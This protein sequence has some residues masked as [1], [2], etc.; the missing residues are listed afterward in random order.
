[1]TDKDSNT[2][3]HIAAQNSQNASTS[4]V[5]SVWKF[6]EEECKIDRFALNNKQRTARF[7]LT[8]DAL[9]H[10]NIETN[11]QETKC[12]P[13]SQQAVQKMEASVLT[14]ACGI[15]VSKA[16]KSRAGVSLKH[17]DDGSVL[18]VQSTSRILKSQEPLEAKSKTEAKE[19]I[20]PA[21]YAHAEQ[22]E[23]DYPIATTSKDALKKLV[24]DLISKKLD[25]QS[26]EENLV[27]TE[28]QKQE[29]VSNAPLEETKRGSD[30]KTSDQPKVEKDFQEEEKK[31]EGQ[32]WE[33]EIH[34]NVAA[35]TK[36]KAQPYK[37]RQQVF[38]KLYKLASGDWNEKNHKLLVNEDGIEIYEARLTKAVRIL[39]QIVVRFSISLTDI[40]ADHG[41][42]YS[43]G[44]PIHV[45]SE[46]IVVW[47]IVE[48][49]DKIHHSAQRIK[50]AIQNL[51]WPTADMTPVHKTWHT[52]LK[53]DIRKPKVF[54]NSL[55]LEQQLE[56]EIMDKLSC[57]LTPSSD[58]VREYDVGAKVYS[59]TSKLAL[60]FLDDESERKDY[61]IKAT[62]EEHDIIQ[63]PSSK[64]VVVLG[65]SGTGK[66]T[67]CLNRLW[68]N[69]CNWIKHSPQ[70]TRASSGNAT[71]DLI[72]T[73]APAIPQQEN[74]IA[75][76]DSTSTAVTS[77]EMSDIAQA[78]IVETAAVS[79][80]QI[81]DYE[82]EHLHQVFITK[83]P[84][85]CAKMKK[86]FFD[87]IAGSDI[88]RD[89]LSAENYSLPET[90]SNV[91]HFPIF[92]TAREFF[93]ML[94]KSLDGVKFFNRDVIVESS[95]NQA[96]SHSL[97]LLLEQSD[98]DSE[99]ETEEPQRR[100]R[101][102]QIW[103]EITATEFLTDIWPCICSDCPD[104]KID[105]LLIWTEI[106]SFIK[107]SVQAL[108]SKSGYITEG[109]YIQVGAKQSNF[110][111]EFRREVYKLFIQYNNEMKHKNIT[112]YRFD[113]NDLVWN[114]NQR[115]NKKGLRN[116]SWTI[117]ELYIDEVQ[118]FTQ[119]E[120][121][122]IF[123][124]CKDPNRCFL[125]GDTAQTIIQGI[126]FRFED[127]KSM[128]HNFEKDHGIVCTVPQVQKLTINHRSHSSIT[129]L[130]NS[131]IDLLKWYFPDA[132]DW[133][134]IPADQSNMKG[135]TP[136]FIPKLFLENF[137]LH[138]QS[139]ELSSIE[140]GADQVV[141]ARDSSEDGRVKMPDYLQ[142]EIVLN[143]QECKGLE[144][145]DVLLYNL[146]TDTPDQVRLCVV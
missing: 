5:I 128:F 75:A 69:Y 21:I 110:S 50:K 22:A 117:H 109:E 116:I 55:N 138:H 20:I 129:E 29:D 97:S 59:L 61:P 88:T 83:N 24:A 3:L 33:V 131:L 35:F 92:L 8:K 65:R 23:K 13:E 18:E 80:T 145:N 94:D 126:A 70:K 91:Q 46:A 49:H 57:T 122:V 42:K 95:T 100:Q 26:V 38:K 66:T 72:S 30:L 31:F 12:T 34:E 78:S 102:P 81:S 136:F 89:H 37:L 123:K 16:P 139:E 56:I 19:A 121:S 25:F 53:G 87:F 62:D 32:T 58:I 67:T 82:Y 71:P 114:L 107:G 73:E 124:C 63:L 2:P 39:Y 15:Q 17:S 108:S 140:F 52:G 84:S 90:L 85:L 1:M 48:N 10:L 41:L 68:L 40:L 105:P 132:F 133:Q 142:D 134:N 64:P 141:I 11:I 135:P 137:L 96:N 51:K 99:E 98:S 103:R 74:A 143:P 120:L 45:F 27:Q 9:E 104:P 111:V 146:F 115:L 4:L 79:S 28:V 125:A 7:Y 44:K 6:L 106:E 54:V 101:R 130:A 93:T 43:N 119:A 113:S 118:D 47:E 112:K 14:T 60:S 86:R 144:F 127:L 77:T 36:S 76:N